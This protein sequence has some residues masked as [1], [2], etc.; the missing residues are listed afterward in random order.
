MCDPVTIGLAALS[1]VSSG[2]GMIGQM[3]QASYQ[4][5]IADRNA[6]LERE[7]ARQEQENT[8]EAALAH[9]RKIAAT[10]GAQRVAGAAN[11]VSLDFGTAADVVADTEMLGREDV[12]RIYAQGAQAVKGRDIGASNY[13]AEAN[14]QR[15]ARTGALIGGIADMGSSVLGGV[16]QYKTL[17]MNSGGNLAS[18][19][20]KTMNQNRAIF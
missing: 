1:V 19:V 4:A 6:S 13:T 5:K 16:S 2:V 14:A 3:N 17:K 15:S 20:K 7:A 10:K 18:S 9:Y 11:G 8:R 12:G